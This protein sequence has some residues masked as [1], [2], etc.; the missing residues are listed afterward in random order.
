M[1]LQIYAIMAKVKHNPEAPVLIDEYINSMAPFAKAICTKL[2]AIVLSADPELIEDWKWGPNYYKNGMVCGFAAFQKQVNFVFFQGAILKDKR[3]LFSK[4][5]VAIKTRT[6]RFS[7]VSDIN[8]EFL[9]EYIFEAI[10]NN[11]KGIK[12]N[13]PR[14]RE[15]SLPPYLKKEQNK[16][17]M[18]KVFQAMSYSRRSLFVAWIEQ[19]KREE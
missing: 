18:M 6:I 4:N 1:A 14:D 9:L 3:K 5:E 17:G 12:V 16:A 8:E 19:A 11:S 7:K 10:D 2:R 15:V 13:I